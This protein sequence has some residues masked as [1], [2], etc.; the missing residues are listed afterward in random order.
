MQTLDITLVAGSSGAGKTTWI[1]QQVYAIANS[2]LY[3]NLGADAS[4]VDSAYL[5][6]EVPGLTVLPITQLA[7]FL[8]H[9]IPGATVYLELGFHIQQISFKPT[10]SMVR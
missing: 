1:R 8:A 10:T 3:L 2:T 7:N 6:A 4:S 9:P 5:V